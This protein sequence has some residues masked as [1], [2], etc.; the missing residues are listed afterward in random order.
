MKRL[1]NLQRKQSLSDRLESLRRSQSRELKALILLKL[2]VM[3]SWKKCRSQSSENVSNSTRGNNSKKLTSKEKLI[4]PEKSKRQLPSWKKPKRLRKLV[5]GEKLKTMPAERRNK[6]MPP[7]YKQEQRLPVKKD[8]LRCMEKLKQ[9]RK[10]RGKRRL[11][12]L[13]S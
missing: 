9:K 8:C 10:R 4:S 12:L 2:E 11:D 7:L 5:N 6:M 1:P 3:V 13:K